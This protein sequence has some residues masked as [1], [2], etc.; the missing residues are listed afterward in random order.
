VLKKG[1]RARVVSLPSWDI[2]AQ[3]LRLEFPAPTDVGLATPG[4]THEYDGA[5]FE[6]PTDLIETKIT[7]PLSA[8]HPRWC[9]SEG[10]ATDHF[11]VNMRRRFM[12]SLR[13]I[14]KEA[15]AISPFVCEF[16]KLSCLIFWSIFCAVVPS[17]RDV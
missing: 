16:G 15:E 14:L 7:F 12:S 1:I 5:G 2:F 13:S 4:R 3:V 6:I 17:I 11:E 8:A 9:E 10:D